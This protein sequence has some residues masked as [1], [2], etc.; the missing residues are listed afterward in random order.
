MPP[1]RRRGSR[2]RSR[3]RPILAVLSV[4]A[5]RVV[6]LRQVARA[7]PLE[8]AATVADP[9]EIA[10]LETALGVP[11]PTVEAFVRGV[12]Q[13]GG[14]LGRECDGQPGWKTIWRGYQKL[15]LLVEGARLQQRINQPQHT[16]THIADP[17]LHDHPP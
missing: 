13:L 2:T 5:V 11:V 9:L 16:P 10:V 17:N 12:A 14:F 7:C 1:V 8:P 3:C 15:L 4:V 6:Q